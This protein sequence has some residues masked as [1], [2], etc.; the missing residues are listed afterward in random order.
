MELDTDEAR[1]HGRPGGGGG[2]KVAE[3]AQ[4]HECRMNMTYNES[5]ETKNGARVVYCLI[6]TT[7]NYSSV[8]AL[9]TAE[10]YR[11]AMV[12]AITNLH[13]QSGTVSYISRW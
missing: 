2:G 8:A 12:T 3:A 7:S 11:G 6:P 1:D 4:Q 10:L 5:T 13:E 9:A